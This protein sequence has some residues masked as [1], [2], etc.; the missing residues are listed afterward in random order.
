[1]GHLLSGVWRG[2]PVCALGSLSD[3]ASEDQGFDR[4]PDSSPH[5][6]IS[7]ASAIVHGTHRLFLCHWLPTPAVDRLWR[8][9]FGRIRVFRKFFG[10]KAL[11]DRHYG[12]RHSL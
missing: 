10:A 5:S 12:L 7:S 8:I 9:L 11:G 2:A 3:R 6:S 4:C 1:M